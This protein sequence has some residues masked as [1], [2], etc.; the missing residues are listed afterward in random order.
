MISS[1]L[2]YVR[3][4]MKE[5]KIRRLEKNLRV[6]EYYIYYLEIYFWLLFK[7]I[8]MVWLRDP[9][10]LVIRMC[11]KK[12]A[13]VIIDLSIMTQTH[14]RECFPNIIPKDNFLEL[15][16]NTGI[17][18]A[19]Y[20]ICPSEI[21]KSW[22]ESN[23]ENKKIYKIEFGVNYKSDI[24]VKKSNIIAY[25]GANTERKG[26]N[27]YIELSKE[28]NDLVF[29]TFGRGF[30][31]LNNN[32]IYNNGFLQTIDYSR[33]GVV[34]LPTYMEGMSKAALE[35]L[36]HGCLLV[37]SIYSGIPKGT[38]GVFWCNPDSLDSI[39]NALFSALKDLSNLDY[40]NNCMNKN[41][42]FF[43]VECYQARL[44]KCLDNLKIS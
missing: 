17:K 9:H 6:I 37:T 32:K 10:P 39:R 43:G 2:G 41:R 29:E 30:T 14:V 8:Y 40:R 24:I 7:E 15:I 28:F 25:I 27:A 13:K 22:L 4:Y 34:V 16:E 42:Q 38:P 31:T 33:I 44:S 35:A 23:F 12:K 20:V 18:L 21:M 1:L 36:C 19:D 3:A 5:K 26:I 11:H